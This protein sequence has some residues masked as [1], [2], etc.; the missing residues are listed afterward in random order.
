MYKLYTHVIL[1]LFKSC[2]A[3]RSLV[4]AGLIL[5]Y[6]TLTTNASKEAEGKTEEGRNGLLLCLGWGG[7][8]FAAHRRLETVKDGSQART[9]EGGK[10]REGG[11]AVLGKSEGGGQ[12]KGE[13]QWKNC[14][15][16]SAIMQ[17][18]FTIS[19]LR[20]WTIFRHCVINVSKITFHMCKS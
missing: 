20:N 11:R 1:S 10:E 5:P 15:T 2:W 8:S 9:G 6:G 18:T 16:L 3:Q 19:I 13:R 17:S 4:L 14:E 7:L 12:N